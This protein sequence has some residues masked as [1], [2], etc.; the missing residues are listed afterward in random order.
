MDHHLQQLKEENK[1][2]IKLVCCLAILNSRDGSRINRF[3]GSTPQMVVPTYFSAFFFLRSQIIISHY[4]TQ[5]ISLYIMPEIKDCKMWL[6][7]L[8]VSSS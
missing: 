8:F 4:Q 1:L 5:L 7:Q 6:L 2:H 3:G